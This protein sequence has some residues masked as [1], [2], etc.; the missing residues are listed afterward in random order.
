MA[1]NL[2]FDENISET[3]PPYGSFEPGESIG[4]QTDGLESV[5]KQLCH[6]YRE[7]FPLETIALD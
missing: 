5:V 7:D 3:G 1:I 4:K 2:H 6:L